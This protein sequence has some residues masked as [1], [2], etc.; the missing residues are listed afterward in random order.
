MLK[1]MGYAFLLLLLI[2]SLSND[3]IS[4]DGTSDLSKLLPGQIK[5][6]ILKDIPE[7]LRGDDLFLYIN[8][9]ADIYHEY[10][11]EE[12]ISAEYEQVGAGR[13]SVE[14]YKMKDT[15][16]AFGI[17]TFRTGG[18]WGKTCIGNLYSSED[19]YINILLGKNLVTIT[20]IDINKITEK[21]IELIRKSLERRI[22]SSVAYPK[23]ARTIDPEQ[24]KNRIY[25]K[26]DLGMMNIYNL[27]SAESGIL[28]GS[29]GIEKNSIIFVLE[30]DHG[31]NTRK[32]LD[33]LLTLFKAEERYSEFTIKGQSISFK[34]RN[35]KILL[36]SVIKDYIVINIGENLTSCKKAA[37]NF[38]IYSLIT[39]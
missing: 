28:H 18:K 3:R 8:G 24:Y 9:G 2:I 6:W 23:I 10:G 21:G 12:V 39:K 32:K 14:I 36:L 1:Y 11:F 5:D 38:T 25:F 7:V 19:Y 15:E 26:G 30:F 34:D 37:K 31:T 33:H 13:I 4:A 27:F 20:S 16:S 22:V 29:S 17:F 35:K